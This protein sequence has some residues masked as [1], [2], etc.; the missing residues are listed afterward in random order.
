MRTPQTRPRFEKQLGAGEPGEDGNPRLFHFAAQPL[1]ELVDRDDVVSVI[2][3]GR[4]RDGELEFAR[5]GQVV[6][7]F[8]DDLGVERR[9]L[10]EAG[11]QLAHGARIEQR[12]GEAM[13]SHLARLL[14][15]VN[16]LF[17]EL[18]VGMVG[19]VLI[20]ELRQAQRAGHAG[21]ASADDDYVGFHYRAL[22][23]RERLTKNDH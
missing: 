15:D 4:R 2:A 12:S 13:R 7:R 8:F 1:H 21:R 20:D 18:G 17:G 11:Q 6:D 19:V 14:Q 3:H 9:F 10:L 23:I 16:I 5:P 22:D